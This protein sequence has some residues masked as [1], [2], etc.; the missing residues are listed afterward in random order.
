MPSTLQDQADG[1]RLYIRPLPGGGYVAIVANTVRPL[2]AGERFRGQIL[3]ER[4]AES[5]RQ[6]HKAP[7]AACA[8]RDALL[9]VLHALMPI[10][11]SDSALGDALTR[12]VTI[13]V[14]RRRH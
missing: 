12:K 1:K 14:R 4:R 9:E 13:P 8:E 11:Q 7:V 5:R 3:V 10:A 6:G 2:F